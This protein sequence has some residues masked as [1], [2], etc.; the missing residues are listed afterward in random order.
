MDE[1][2]LRLELAAELGDPEAENTLWYRLQSLDIGRCY[3]CEVSTGLW[4]S[5]AGYNI[6]ELLAD[7]RLYK[8]RA[9]DILQTSDF[10]I[11]YIAE[12]YEVLNIF[13]RYVAKSLHP[14]T[15]ICYE[16]YE[17]W[18]QQQL[19]E[20]SSAGRTFGFALEVTK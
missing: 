17:N 12:Q 2:L 7:A 6:S 9:E 4:S 18:K 16:C 10:D 11:G 13:N 19:G 20:P 8:Q 3:F 15:T 5:P 1:E 14:G